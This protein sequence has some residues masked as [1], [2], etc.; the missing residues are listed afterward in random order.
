M[1]QAVTVRASLG[2]FHLRDGTRLLRCV[3]GGS[4][5]APLLALLEGA[6]ANT[7]RQ[8]PVSLLMGA[9]TLRDL[10]CYYRDEIAALAARWQAPF[11]F[12]PVLSEEADGSGWRGQRGWVT[13][14]IT[15]ARCAAQG[16][17]FGP[18]PMVDAGIAVMTA[19]GIAREAILFDKF[20]DQSL[21]QP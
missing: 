16:Y 18:P 17:L 1:D 7:A 14:A 3:A 6:A 19:Q 12:I 8:R 20:S 9:R 10:Y 2:E 21:T 5:L 11:D 15:A 13:E 4:G